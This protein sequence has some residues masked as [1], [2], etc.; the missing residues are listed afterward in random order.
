MKTLRVCRAGHVEDIDDRNSWHHGGDVRCCVI[1][2]V[3]PDQH[4]WCAK[5]VVDVTNPAHLAAYRLGG[6]K[7]LLDILDT[8]LPLP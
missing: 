6:V 7:A 2:I 1:V 4:T 8:E 5:Q 3:R